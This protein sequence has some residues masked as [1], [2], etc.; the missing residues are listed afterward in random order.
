M[1]RPKGFSSVGLSPDVTANIRSWG[2]GSAVVSRVWSEGRLDRS[3]DRRRVRRQN[4]LPTGHSPLLG[5]PNGN[6]GSF[7]QNASNRR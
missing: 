6:A 5:S 2:C 4:V 1:V 7:S 3:F